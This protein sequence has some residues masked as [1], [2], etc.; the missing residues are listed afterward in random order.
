VQNHGSGLDTNSLGSRGESIFF[1][2]IT[3]FHG[4]AP[5]FKPAHPGDKWAVA[6]LRH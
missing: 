3:E 4:N 1:A 5:L 2:R 6:E